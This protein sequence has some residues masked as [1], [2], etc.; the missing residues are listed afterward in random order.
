[1]ANMAE[2]R[3]HQDGIAAQ[4]GPARNRLESS[5][6]D[7]L[8]ELTRTMRENPRFARLISLAMRRDCTM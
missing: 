5:A 1:M 8:E 3:V 7:A 6:T 4:M 2:Q